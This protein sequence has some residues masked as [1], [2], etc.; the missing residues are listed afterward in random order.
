ACGA[1]GARLPDERIVGVVEG[2]LRAEAQVALA[3]R[4]RDREAVALDG[5]GPE[6]IEGDPPLRRGHG[7]GGADEPEQ[8]GA[9]RRHAAG[10]TRGVHLDS[11]SS[12][13]VAPTGGG[14]GLSSMF[15]LSVNRSRLNHEYWIFLLSAKHDRRFGVLAPHSE[16][17]RP[18]RPTSRRL[19]R[20]GEAAGP[21]GRGRGRGGCG[22]GARRGAGRAG[23]G[24]RRRPRAPWGALR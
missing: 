9:Q 13:R 2:Q 21:R 12:T 8:G 15:T 14:A 11:R 20:S 3:E 10:T 4:V 1:A 22:C 6:E 7:G 24:W 18:K 5:R 23:R 17:S 19:R 16:H